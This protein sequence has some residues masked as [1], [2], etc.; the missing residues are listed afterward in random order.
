M[1]SKIV[2]AFIGDNW[3]VKKKKEM[4]LPFSS[5]STLHFV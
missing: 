4:E 1:E 3:F 2:S 5:L